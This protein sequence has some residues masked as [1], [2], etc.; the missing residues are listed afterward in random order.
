MRCIPALILSFC[1]LALPKSHAGILAQFRTIFGDIDV[2]LFEKDKPVTVS[3]FIA[4]VQS[5]TRYTAPARE[6]T[7]QPVANGLA[8]KVTRV[9]GSQFYVQKS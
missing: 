9:V 7:G 3:N 4:Y 2:E 5:G 8:V 6:E 1:L